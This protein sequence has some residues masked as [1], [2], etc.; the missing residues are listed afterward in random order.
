M[1][2]V[3][4]VLA[5]PGLSVD[6]A[7]SMLAAVVTGHP[8]AVA[9]RLWMRL[10]VTYIDMIEPPPTRLVEVP[11]ASCNGL[12]MGCRECDGTGYVEREQDESG[13]PA[14]TDRGLSPSPSQHA[15]KGANASTEPR[16]LGPKDA[17]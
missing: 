2:S 6:V 5:A 17:S 11:C 15:S 3:E 12:N 9:N 7:R 4:E 14:A 13:G 16:A 1:A 8:E 10:L